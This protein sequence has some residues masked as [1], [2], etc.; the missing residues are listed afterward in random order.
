[1]QLFLKQFRTERQAQVVQL[2]QA[3][4]VSVPAQ[5][6]IWC[7]PCAGYRSTEGLQ[8]VGRYQICCLLY[9]APQIDS[10]TPQFYDDITMCRW[11]AYEAV[12][13]IGVVT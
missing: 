9:L 8:T 10:M 12:L 11:D 2:I 1:M 7:V 3:F 4:A 6:V 5:N 13:P